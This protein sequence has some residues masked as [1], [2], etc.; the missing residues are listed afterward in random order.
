MTNRREEIS[1][2]LSQRE[3]RI[4]GDVVY[5]GDT[6]GQYFIRIPVNRGADN[7]QNPS[8][9]K[10]AEARAALE[11]S[12]FRVVFLLTDELKNDIEAGLRATLLH[13]DGEHVRNVFMSSI[14]DTPH[15]WIETKRELTEDVFEFIQARI[16]RYLSEFKIVP[17]SITTTSGYKFPSILACMRCI[18]KH[19]PIDVSSINAA[20]SS[21][22]FTIPS[23]DWLKRRLD[24]MRKDGA[25]IWLAGNKY[26]L[27]M[28]SIR[29]LGTS[30]NR[31]SPD[32]SRLLA[33][34]R[35]TR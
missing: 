23:E 25:I 30:K 34:A 11:S 10:L 12:G 16:T 35:W 31:T 3:I 28:S 2:I 29:K 27:P 4:S 17:K 19:A 20:L 14:A 26:C 7:K 15:V 33:L 5:D 24:S 22:G 32:V 21:D 8:H 18:R 13:H 1:D 9:S 6:G